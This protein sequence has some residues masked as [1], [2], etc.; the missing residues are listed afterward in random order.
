MG[1]NQT[2]R[3]F[4]K[5]GLALSAAGLVST[6]GIRPSFGQEESEVAFRT[7]GKTGLKVSG[8]GFGIGFVPI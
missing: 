8:V 5:T 3:K 2:R 4:L 1:T 6:T 7:L